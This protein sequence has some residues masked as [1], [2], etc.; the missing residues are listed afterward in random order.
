MTDTST[1]DTDPAIPD[2]I[3]IFLDGTGHGRA[4]DHGEWN[5]LIASDAPAGF[6]WVHLQSG[7]PGTLDVLH[8]LGL[9]ATVIDALTAEET[10]PRCMV[11]EDGLLLNLR[12]VNLNPGAELEDMVSVRFWMTSRQVIGVWVRPLFAIADLRDAIERGMGP[13]SPGDFASKLALRLA[14]RAEPQ[15]A[16]LNERIDALEEAVMRDE[17]ATLRPELSD[18]RRS[19]ILLRRYMIPQKDALTTME[20]EDVDWLS[21]RDRLRLREAAERVGRLGED[22]DAIR[23]RAQVVHDQIMDRRAEALNSRMLIIAV[24]SA[25]FLP[26]SLIAGLLGMNVG[27][28]PGSADPAAF[29]AV[30]GLVV[31]IGIG[32]VIWLW[33]TGVFR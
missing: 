1:P 20:I 5:S 26:L 16:T 27:G 30:V 6:V 15:A 8:E 13:V 3:A 9:D 21:Q 23:D 29:W 31:L 18:L 7:A 11:H 10:R 17:V 4:L 32:L 28:I 12:G 25:I 22:L 14:D 19:S 33:K 24:I 2:R